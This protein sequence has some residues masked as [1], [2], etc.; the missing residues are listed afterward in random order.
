V[1]CLVLTDA[2]LLL[3]LILMNGVF[4]MS[5]LA[6]VG[7]RRSRLAHMAK[8][9]HAGAARAAALSSD[10]M[11]F[12]STVQVGI[13]TVG[14]LSGAVGQATIAGRLRLALERIPVLAPHAE[15]LSLVLMVIGLTYASLVIGELVPKRLALTHPERIATIIAR[16]MQMLATIGHP[17]VAVL[18]ASTDAVLRFLRVRKV[19][20]PVVSMDEFKVLIDQ[21]AAQG[22]FEKTEQEL[23]TNILNLDERDVS[24]ILTPRSDILFLDV[25]ES[26]DQ[27]R[28]K[29]SEAQHSVV[30]LCDGGLDHVLGFI[31]SND[32]LTR[33]LRSEALDL[34]ALALP[35]LFVPRTVSLMRLLEQFKRTHLPVGLVVDEFGDV[36]GLVSLTDV[37]SAIV[38]E[39]PGEPGEE[40][41]VVT[42]QD[43]SWLIDGTL[44]LDGV[45]R[46]ISLDSLAGEEEETYH[47]LGGLAMRALGRVP[48]TGDVF[49]QQGFRFEVVDMDGNRVDRVLVSRLPAQTGEGA[50]PPSTV[51][52]DG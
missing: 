36:D 1:K 28:E 45:K 35:P 7:S 14:I 15:G 48:R 19:K 2:A 8:D 4:A 25:R 9:G 16:P 3:A 38:G 33:L 42:R 44:D 5:E 18:S 10:P 39:L 30:P 52:K 27:S 31:R 29:L 37:M 23:V 50:V 11:R 12:L 51:A 21:A 40:P 32:V 46:A 17:V 26:L 34:K 47:T 6:I 20:E 13:T 22:V 24:E 41:A 43:G 49:E